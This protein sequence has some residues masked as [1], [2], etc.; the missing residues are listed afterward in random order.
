VPTPPATQPDG[1]EAPDP[2]V[3]P[4]PNTAP[5]GQGAEPLDAGFDA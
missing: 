3:I 2:N 5:E 1:I 4:D